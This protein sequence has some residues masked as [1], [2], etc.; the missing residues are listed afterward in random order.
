MSFNV[1]VFCFFASYLVAMGLEFFRFLGR[2]RLSQLATQGFAAAGLVAHTLYILNRAQQT[3]LPPLLSSTHDWLLVLSWLAVI[4]YLTLTLFDRDLAVGVFLLPI[5][6]LC[7][8]ATYFVS[9]TP[10]AHL[11][12]LRGWKMLHA[13]LLVLGMLGVIVGFVLSLMY[14]FQQRRLRRREALSEGFG[15]PNL[16][17]LA[18]LNRWAILISVPMLTFGFATGVGLGFVGRTEASEFSFTDPLV[19]ASGIT[20]LGMVVLFTWLLTGRRPR[21]RQVALL[22]IW[23]CGF[24]L[25]TVVGLQLLTG[26]FHGSAPD[27]VAAQSAV[28]RLNQWR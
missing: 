20:W 2:S 28:S 15:V 14:L 5:I 4:S 9:Q 19:L 24:L 10:V 17:R 22:T 3:G 23:A 12:A 11:D 16:E 18:R 21:G 13:S 27:K 26:Q 8:V 1:Q 6:L 7:V 25:V